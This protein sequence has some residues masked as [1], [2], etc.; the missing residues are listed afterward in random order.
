MGDNRVGMGPKHLEGRLILLKTF[1][2][3]R[4]SYRP[5]PTIL[6]YLIKWIARLEGPKFCT[7][8]G[9]KQIRIIGLSKKRVYLCTGHEG[10][11]IIEKLRR[12]PARE[13]K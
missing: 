10:D 4:S 9:A 12:P 13:K 1:S 11:C 8:G 2:I 5:F 7:W 3:S 6:Q